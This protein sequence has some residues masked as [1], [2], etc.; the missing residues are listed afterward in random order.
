MSGLTHPLVSRPAYGVAGLPGVGP[1]ASP[2]RENSGLPDDEQRP[3]RRPTGVAKLPEGEPADR[4]LSLDK[5]IPGTSTYNKPEGDIREFDKAEPGSIYRREGPDD[6]AKPQSGSPKDDSTGDG[7]D[8]EYK[9]NFGSPGKRAPD[10]PT[11]TTYPYRDKAKHP[12]YAA[13]RQTQAEVVA[14]LFLLRHAHEALLRPR[15]NV[16]TAAKIDN[17]STGL[18]PAIESRGAKC[19][20]TLRRVDKDNLRWLFAV[21]CGNGAKVVKLKAERVGNIVRLAKMNLRVSCSCPAWRWLGPEYHAKKEK[22]LDGRPAGTASTPDIM[23]PQR[24]HLVCKHV[25]AILHFVRKWE[26]PLPAEGHTHTQ[27]R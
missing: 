6:Q 20:V 13:D 18:D 15:P 22:Y 23:D 16:R 9:P 4:G 12:H 2:L 27:M 17:L 7:R 11:F 10:D 25:S 24:N 1:G 5:D 14:G 19:S 21:D 8:N 26:V 3:G